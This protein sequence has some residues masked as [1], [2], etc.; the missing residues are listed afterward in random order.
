MPEKC[1]YCGKEFENTKALGSHIHYVHENESWANMS[2][3]R[4]ESDKERFQKLLDSCLS[5][6]DLRRPRQ[7]EKM[8][9]AIREIPEGVSQT[10]D[11]YRGAYRCAIEKEKLVKEFEEEL[12]KE[13]SSKE[14]K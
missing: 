9:Q 13:E 2:Q 10:I 7:L 8:E 1:Q 6:R 11:Q 5:A 12:A 3:I 4:S 14:T